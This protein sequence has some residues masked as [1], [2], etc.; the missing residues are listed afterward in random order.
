MSEK[1]TEI[2]KP[3]DNEMKLKLS[4]EYDFEDYLLPVLFGDIYRTLVAEQEVKLLL[5]QFSLQLGSFIPFRYALHPT[6]HGRFR[7]RCYGR[8]A[9]GGRRACHDGRSESGRILRASRG[10]SF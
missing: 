6:H 5:G 7:S 9:E 2:N 8:I 10:R 3:E 4:K 1:V